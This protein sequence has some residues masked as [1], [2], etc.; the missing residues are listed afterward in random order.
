[1]SNFRW[2]EK[3]TELR[4]FW[5]TG[6][7]RITEQQSTVSNFEIISRPV[8]RDPERVLMALCLVVRELAEL[9]EKRQS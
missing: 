5:D 4:H 8:G 6:N 9:E 3:F 1:M 2:N 7:S